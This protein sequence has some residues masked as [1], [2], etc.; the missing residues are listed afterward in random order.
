MAQRIKG[1]EVEV[2]L[3]LNGVAQKSITDV[4]NFDMSWLTEILKEGYLGETTMRYDAIFNGIKGKIELHF[5]NSDVFNLIQNIIDKAQRRLPG[6]RINVKA[7]LNFPNGQ[8][9]RVIVP[10]VEFGEIP[11]NFGSRSDY[12]SIS[13]DFNAAQAS[14][15]F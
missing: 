7:T 9:V 5:E 3:V 8:R 2:I 1:Q 11:M 10:N 6:T 15:I 13:L 14:T 12:G 4:R